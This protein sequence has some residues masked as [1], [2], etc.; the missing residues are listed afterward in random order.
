[1]M[2]ISAKAPTNITRSIAST[3]T[4]K[5]RGPA[6]YAIRTKVNF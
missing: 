5:L 2:D 6:M 3:N 1:M 4:S